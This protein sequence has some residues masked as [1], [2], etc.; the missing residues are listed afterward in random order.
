[1]STNTKIVLITIVSTIAVM[2]F[3]T[4]LLWL[5]GWVPQQ[6]RPRFF[7]V[8]KEQWTRSPLDIPGYNV[9]KRMDYSYSTMRR[10][11]VYVQL[12]DTTTITEEQAKM[13]ANIEYGSNSNATWDEFTVFI[14]SAR[15]TDHTMAAWNIKIQKGAV[16]V[17]K[18]KNY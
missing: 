18:I 12:T 5:A 17:N 1:M 11:A 3:I 7:D 2:S 15:D 6:Q 13:I 8:V 10:Y 9:F 4:V 16:R 14:F